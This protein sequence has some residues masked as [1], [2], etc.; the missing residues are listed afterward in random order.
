ML[1]RPAWWNSRYPAPDS[2]GRSPP[3]APEADDLPAASLP[4]GRSL[5]AVPSHRSLKDYFRPYTL[6]TV[7]ADEKPETS[8][9]QNI[10]GRVMNDAS[11]GLPVQDMEPQTVIAFEN[12]HVPHGTFAAEKRRGISR[13]RFAD[14]DPLSVFVFQ[15][16]QIRSRQPRIATPGW[17]VSA[18]RSLPAPGAAVRLAR[19]SSFLD[20]NMIFGF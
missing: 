2:R 11:A 20:M 17:S 9:M 19:R 1:R 16:P 3:T 12:D 10:I 18:T 13:S 8:D 4:A 5:F 15:Q 6:R 14:R 7:V